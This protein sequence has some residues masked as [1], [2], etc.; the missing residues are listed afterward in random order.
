MKNVAITL[1]GQ[2]KDM[3]LC[4]RSTGSDHHPSGSRVGQLLNEYCCTNFIK[5]RADPLG[6]KA[7]MAQT[8]FDPDPL[9]VAVSSTNLCPLQLH[10]NSD[11]GDC[12]LA[13]ASLQGLAYTEIILLT[14]F[15]NHL[16]TVPV[17]LTIC[18]W[19]EAILCMQFRA[20]VLQNI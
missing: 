10:A 8:Q 12:C 5:A 2:I 19:I 11:L 7:L 17:P 4:L 20:N 16:S 13:A 15:C 6:H 1:Q 3:A 9:A 14:C 18:L